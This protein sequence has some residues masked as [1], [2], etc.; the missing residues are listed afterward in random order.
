[1]QFGATGFITPHDMTRRAVAATGVPV[2]AGASQSS[3][4]APA[5]DYD[6]LAAAVSGSSRGGVS[7]GQ[8]VTQRN[9]TAPELAEHLSF[10]AR[11]R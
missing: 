8:I 10:L 9:E 2:G 4:G 11:T 5:I 6:R 7:I 1:M 3:A